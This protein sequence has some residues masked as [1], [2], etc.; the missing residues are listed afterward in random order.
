MSNRNSDDPGMPG[1]FL[2]EDGRLRLSRLGDHIRF[3]ARLA[4]P[5]MRDEERAWAPEMPMGGFAV[6]LE[7][8]AEQVDHVLGEMSW[9][10]PRQCG[11]N[12]TDGDGM[13]L[14]ATAA[15]GAARRRFA[16]GVTLDQI[17]ALDR[18]VQ[19]M[20]AHGDVVLA[21]HAAELAEHTLPLIGQMICD[22]AVAVRAILDDVEAQRLGQGARARTGVG[23][24]R[25][26]YRVDIARLVAERRPGRVLRR[27]RPGQDRG[28]ILYRKRRRSSGSPASFLRRPACPG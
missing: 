2:P 27:R 21:G 5:R 18:L 7:L 28:G 22:A 24:A 14:A 11:T 19:A 8:L 4:Q 20:S 10:A 6:C 3:L 17:D 23:E 15:P 16:F 13:S 1:Y 25:R 26:A 9:S 12:A